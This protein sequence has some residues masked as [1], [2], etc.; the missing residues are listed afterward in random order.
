[1]PR[2][3]LI[4]GTGELL[5]ARLG[6]DAD[7]RTGRGLWRMVAR[8]GLRHCV[9]GIWR[10]APVAF[11]ARPVSREAEPAR[12]HRL[13]P[14]G[15]PGGCGRGPVLWYG[16]YGAVVVYDPAEQGKA[17]ALA[18]AAGLLREA[19]ALSRPG[20]GPVGRVKRFFSA[21]LRR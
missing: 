2:M 11:A 3:S 5:G 6:L 16:V 21:V 20:H 9:V 19:L 4:A 8:R 18:A 7:R 13:G 12:F 1:M 14:R 17:L 10:L 15:G